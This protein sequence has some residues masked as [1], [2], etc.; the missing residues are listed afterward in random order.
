MNHSVLCLQITKEELDVCGYFKCLGFSHVISF[1]NDNGLSLTS[2]K[3]QR[4][5]M[6]NLD[7]WDVASL[8]LFLLQHGRI[9]LCKKGT[10]D[11]TKMDNGLESRPE[12]K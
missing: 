10:I 5:I 8:N 9:I 12:K 7:C 1:D 3:F 6:E 11:L 2:D 4:I